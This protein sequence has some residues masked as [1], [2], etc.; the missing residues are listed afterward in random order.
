VERELYPAVLTR[1]MTALEEGRDISSVTKEME[2][3]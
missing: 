2:D 1:V 3:V